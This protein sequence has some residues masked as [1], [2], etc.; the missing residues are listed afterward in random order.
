MQ[1]LLVGSPLVLEDEK[2]EQGEGWDKGA[3]ERA[4]EV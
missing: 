3:A 1:Q 2:R 4:V